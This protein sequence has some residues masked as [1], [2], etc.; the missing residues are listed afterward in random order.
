MTE[1]SEH[2]GDARLPKGKPAPRLRQLVHE[3]IRRR[4]FSRR[5]EEAYVQWI[6]RFI[7]FPAGAIRRPWESRR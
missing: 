7:Y 4:Y 6:K 5:T 3:A 2:S 1:Q